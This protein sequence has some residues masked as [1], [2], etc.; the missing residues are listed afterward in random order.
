MR[1]IRWL[2]LILM[3]F[4]SELCL[5]NNLTSLLVSK[6]KIV[7]K[8]QTP[9]A[10][11]SFIKKFDWSKA[12]FDT[13]FP[14]DSFENCINND[15]VATHKLKYKGRKGLV[16]GWLVQPKQ[17]HNATKSPLIIFN[18]GGAAKWGRLIM[19]DLLYFCQLA[20][21]GYTVLASDF[22]GSKP[23]G[24]ED[25]PP[26]L[27]VTDLGYGDV[28]DSIDLISLA[29]E[30]GTVDINKIALWGF[31]RGTMIN[32]LMLTKVDNIKAVIMVG[33]V[34]QTDDDFRRSEFD[35]H[36]Y[37]LIV[38]DWSLLPKSEQQKLLLGV[39]PLHLIDDIRSKPA[40][41]FLHGA[42][43]KRTPASRMLEYVQ[44]LQAQK[45]TIE[46]RLYS[47]GTHNLFKYQ[48]TVMKEILRWLDL[49]LKGKEPLN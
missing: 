19:A 35:E 2:T 23:S 45:H 1:E 38:E 27:D 24:S 4:T 22:R 37:P 39:S 33:A 34:S 21:Q 41:L 32:A 44:A 20:E 11:F 9:E 47:E 30:L 25:E 13:S 29:T 12:L 6:E 48:P 18:R 31:S 14:N 36:V 3:S 42:K 49:H 26:L 43:D 17:A 28:C 15:T 8:I 46:L 7:T 10:Y 16:D 5:A 40:F